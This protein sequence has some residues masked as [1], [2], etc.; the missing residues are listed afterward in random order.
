MQYFIQKYLYPELL[1]IA[2]FVW[3]SPK[4]AGKLKSSVD[5]L[6]KGRVGQLTLT[7]EENK[8]KQRGMEEIR[9]QL[10]EAKVPRLQP[11]W[12]IQGYDFLVSN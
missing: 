5:T 4:V 11:F 8:V 1:D 6:V 9:Q 12:L 7:Y 3:A 10:G 2:T